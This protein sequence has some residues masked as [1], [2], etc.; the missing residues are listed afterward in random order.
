MTKVYWGPDQ[1][2][3]YKEYITKLLDELKETREFDNLDAYFP[4]VLF[5]PETTKQ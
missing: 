2:A 1:Q 5:V 4:L 3:M